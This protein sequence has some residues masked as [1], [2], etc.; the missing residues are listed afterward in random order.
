MYVRYYE[1]VSYAAS[2]GAGRFDS[3]SLA[4]IVVKDGVRIPDGRKP[5]RVLHDG[6][7]RPGSRERP[8]YFRRI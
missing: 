1:V 2:H 4:E 5:K 3:G 8:A 7:Q 6:M